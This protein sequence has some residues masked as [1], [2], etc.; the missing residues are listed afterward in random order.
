MTVKFIRVNKTA[1]SPLPHKLNN[2]FLFSS[3]LY[4]L[5]KFLEG[6]GQYM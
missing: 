3:L 6:G 1:G 2:L 5:K 4:Y